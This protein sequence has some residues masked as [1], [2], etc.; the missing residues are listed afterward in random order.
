MQRRLRL[1]SKPESFYMGDFFLSQA[2]QLAKIVGQPFTDNVQL[3]KILR[4]IFSV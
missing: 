1:E 3:M 4:N 2:E